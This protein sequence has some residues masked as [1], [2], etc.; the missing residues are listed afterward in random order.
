METP[1]YKAYLSDP[2]IRQEIDA[3]VRRARAQAVRQYIVAPLARLAGGIIRRAAALATHTPP[4]H[5][6]KV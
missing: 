2:R 5:A 6:T 1:T 4:V 3:E